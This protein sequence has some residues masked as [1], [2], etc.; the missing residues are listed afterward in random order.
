M[1]TELTA[2]GIG[3]ISTLIGAAIS[4][5]AMSRAEQRRVRIAARQA[6][7]L[8]RADLVRW[9]VMRRRAAEFDMRFS[10]EHALRWKDVSAGSLYFAPGIGIALLQCYFDRE[11]AENAISD[12]EQGTLDPKGLF[13]ARFEVHRSAVATRVLLEWMNG[14]AAVRRGSGW[15]G[16]LTRPWSRHFLHVVN[17]NADEARVGEAFRA[18]IRKRLSEE[19]NYQLTRGGGLAEAMHTPEAHSALWVRYRSQPAYAGRDES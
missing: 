19:F 12:I 7:Q 17:T 18:E 10:P 3:F 4:W 9:E 14:Y 8:V 1:T 13:A 11:Q 16:R 15:R 6:E 2:A 5:L